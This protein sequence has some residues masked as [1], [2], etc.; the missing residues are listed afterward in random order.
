MVGMRQDKLRLVVQCIVGDFMTTLH[1]AETYTGSAPTGAPILLAHP[2]MHSHCCTAQHMLCYCRTQS[3]TSHT[4]TDPTPRRSIL[5]SDLRPSLG[6]LMSAHALCCRRT[7][8]TV[9]HTLYR[10]LQKCASELPSVHGCAHV[11]A[12]QL[13]ISALKGGRLYLEPQHTVIPGVATDFDPAIVC[14]RES[15]VCC[16]YAGRILRRAADCIR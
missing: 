9:E 10:I 1:D 3:A 13:L 15:H 6:W 8:V 4:K 16:L 14:C 5:S 2:Y 11:S 12:F 7:S